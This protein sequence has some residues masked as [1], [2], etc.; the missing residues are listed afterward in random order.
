MA[1]PLF[2]LFLGERLIALLANTERTEHQVAMPVHDLGHALHNQVGSQFQR[3]ANGRA[4]K[5]VIDHQQRTGLVGECSESRQV[6]DPQGRVGD[7]LGDYQFGVFSELRRKLVEI[8]QIDLG[9]LDPEAG[10]FPFHDQ[11]RFAIET[12]A[13]QNVIPLLETGNQGQGDGSHAG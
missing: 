3:L 12:V 5:R 11:S 10:E 9:R 4:G 7:R 13:D 8:E 1:V 6:D 2:V